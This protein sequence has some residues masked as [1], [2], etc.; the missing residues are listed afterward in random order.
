ML[1]QLPKYHET[2]EPKEFTA[3]VMMGIERQQRMR[4]LLL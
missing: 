2:P 3:R 1:D 4:R